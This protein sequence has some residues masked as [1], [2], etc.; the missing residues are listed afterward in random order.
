MKEKEQLSR[1]SSY[2]LNDLKR[3]IKH[4]QLRPL[5]PKTDDQGSIVSS[6]SPGPQSHHT[7][8]RKPPT[9]KRNTS[10]KQIGAN[11]NNSNSVKSAKR[12]IAVASADKIGESDSRFAIKKTA[13]PRV[14]PSLA[15]APA[16]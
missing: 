12:S 8:E 16:G 14:V 5:G 4:N 11:Q 13:K 3:S 6:H 2:K 7:E 15:K 9:Y 10:R 1:I